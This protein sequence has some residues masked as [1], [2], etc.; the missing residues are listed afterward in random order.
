MLPSTT[1][2]SPSWRTGSLSTRSRSA[3]TASAASADGR[4]RS[5][6]ANSS[7]PSRAMVSTER[8][9]ADSRPATVRSSSSPAAWPRVSLTC[10]K[11]SRS[12]RSSAQSPPVS[13]ASR[14]RV[15]S[16]VRF[17]RPVRASWAASCAL[18]S[19]CRRISPK[20]RA[21]C[22]PRVTPCR[23]VDRTCWSRSLAAGGR[24]VKPRRSTPSSP[25]RP[26]SGSTRHV[27]PRSSRP[28]LEGRASQS[29]RGSR[30]PGAVEPGDHGGAVAGGQHGELDQVGVEQRAGALHGGCRDV[31]LVQLVDVLAAVAELLP[32]VAVLQRAQVAAVGPVQQGDGDQEQQRRAALP[33]HRRE[34][35]ADDGVAGEDGQLDRQAT[36]GDLA[37]RRPR[38]Q[39]DRG[40][41]GGA[42]PHG[43]DEG[44]D[45]QHE[46]G[47]QR[48]ELAERSAVDQPGDREPD[49]HRPG[50]QRGGVEHHLEQLAAQQQVRRGDGDRP[51]D[52]QPRPG[53]QHQP[54][55]ERG[56][57]P[58]D[59]VAVAPE[60]Q[61]QHGHL[62]E[63]DE[64]R[65]ER[66]APQRRQRRERPGQ[67][68]AAGHAGRPGHHDGR[69]QGA[70][71]PRAAQGAV[72][73]RHLGGDHACAVDR[74]GGVIDTRTGGCPSVRS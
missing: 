28:L 21:F 4:S 44:G 43:V 60:R 53:Q 14:V 68:Q 61:V 74:R 3:A 25:S 63:P 49:Q 9:A 62:A 18:R 70:Q 45:G 39:G 57:G 11:W 64:Q 31:P 2:R 8:V 13:M 20:S 37:D 33:R 5:R 40:R 41:D 36:E 23:N 1:R 52:G 51:D 34:Q 65:G 66:H 56:L 69:H 46:P 48:R 73:G 7:P 26:S 47:A 29:A 17:G 38:R 16:R 27:V 15:C 67:Q 12:T 42:V 10:L 30:R 35:R 50:R 71:G 59:G 24:P 54:D 19:A 72:L 58:G 32:H 22:S 6:T 55:D